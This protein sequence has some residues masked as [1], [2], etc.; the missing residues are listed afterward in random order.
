MSNEHDVRYLKAI[1]DADVY[2][3]EERVNWVKQILTG[4][5]EKGVEVKKPDYSWIRDLDGYSPE[6]RE[7]W[8]QYFE[9][10]DEVEG[11]TDVNPTHYDF[12]GGVQVIDITKHLDFLTGN[13]VKYVSRAGRKGDRLTDLLKARKYLDWAIEKEENENHR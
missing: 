13:V 3:Y 1:L 7:A 6:E 5:P 10:Q 2:S 12:P 4:A 9:G 8:I 11:A